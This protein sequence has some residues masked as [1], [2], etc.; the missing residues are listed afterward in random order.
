VLKY[1][2]VRTRMGTNLHLR[3]IS[4]IIRTM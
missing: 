3:G 2:E 1:S 4:L